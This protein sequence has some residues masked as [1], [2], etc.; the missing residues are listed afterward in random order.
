MFER[1]VYNFNLNMIKFYINCETDVYIYIYRIKKKK[2][3]KELYQ[4]YGKLSVMRH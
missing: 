1:K 4:I 3:R 2:L